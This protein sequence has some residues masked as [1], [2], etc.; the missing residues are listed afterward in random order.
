M[1]LCQVV[2]GNGYDIL[3]AGLTTAIGGKTVTGGHVFEQRTVIERRIRAARRYKWTNQH[4][5]EGGRHAKGRLIVPYPAASIVD[6]HLLAV[7]R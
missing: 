3:S 1:L 7:C 4:F 6:K 2:A 5:N